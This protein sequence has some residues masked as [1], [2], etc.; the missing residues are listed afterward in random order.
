LWTAPVAADWSYR[1]D[2]LRLAGMTR[3]VKAHFE[4]E[5]AREYLPAI[6]ANSRVNVPPPARDIG[7]VCGRCPRAKTAWPRPAHVLD[8]FDGQLPLVLSQKVDLGARPIAA[9]QWSGLASARDQHKVA[10]LARFRGVRLVHHGALPCRYARFDV[11]QRVNS[12]FPR[13][14]D[15]N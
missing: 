8:Q 7:F 11:P 2:Q 14:R 13:I 4:G 6:A 10:V 1:F 3:F 15:H 5:V 12:C 9:R